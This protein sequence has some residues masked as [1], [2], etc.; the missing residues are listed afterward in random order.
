M[1]KIRFVV[2]TTETI[3]GFHNK[4]ATGRS[5][6]LYKYPY[7]ELRLF[8]QNKRGLPEVYNQAILESR[9]DPAVLVFMHDDI[10]LVD[11]FWA[12]NLLEGLKHFDVI[13][14]A[15]NKRRLPRQPAWAFVDEKF[16]WDNR[17]NLTGVVGHGNG[18]PPDMVSIFGN[19][20]YPVKLLDG[21]FLA[22]DSQTLESKGLSFDERF[23]F[24]FYDMDFCRQAEVRGVSMG[25]WSISMIHESGGGFG[26]EAWGEG[27]QRY[28]EKWGS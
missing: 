22:V 20:C 2:A 13:G 17:E 28:L 24:H 26:T 1:K 4:T 3:E 10:H 6:K 18:F 7:V 25:T 11:F 5:L 12:V 19:P 8:E 14:L 9:H 16:T 27:Y 23:D 15:G 21:L